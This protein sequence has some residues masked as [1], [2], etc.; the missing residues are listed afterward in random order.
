MPRCSSM[1][2]QARWVVTVVA[3][4]AITSVCGDDVQSQASTGH[5]HA[6][7]TQM[8]AAP[9]QVA[10]VCRGEAERS[11]FVVLCPTKL[12][13]ATVGTPRTAPPPPLTVE[14]Y[15]LHGGTGLSPGY[16]WYT[17]EFR[18]SSPDEQNPANNYPD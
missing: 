3:L 12:P 18:Y 9:P 5:R 6:Q 11:G 17:I 8:P 15:T 13:R 7:P 1:G 2:R 4:S 16:R 10:R 14:G